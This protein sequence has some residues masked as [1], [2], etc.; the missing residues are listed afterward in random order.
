MVIS[1]WLLDAQG[2]E[3]V[4]LPVDLVTRP[5]PNA[6]QLSWKLHFCPGVEKG[7]EHITAFFKQKYQVWR[8]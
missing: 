4:K 8:D 3:R 7:W 1:K 6:R 2:L 5:G